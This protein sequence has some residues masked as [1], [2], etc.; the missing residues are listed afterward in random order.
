M[1]A[2][3]SWGLCRPAE[4]KSRWGGAEE[5]DTARSSPSELR[6]K[7]R[8]GGGRGQK[9]GRARA[10]GERNS[11]VSG[12]AVAVATDRARTT[13]NDTAR[14]GRVINSEVNLLSTLQKT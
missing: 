12:R 8:P 14:D 5:H 3:L 13:A 6:A 9:L 4:Q 11:L 1:N 10:R 7:G 2:R